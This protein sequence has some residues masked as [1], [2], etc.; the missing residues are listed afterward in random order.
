MGMADRPI[1]NTAYL[2]ISIAL[3]NTTFDVTLIRVMCMIKAEIMLLLM[4]IQVINF[5]H[6]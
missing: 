4:G 5:T 3:Q 6:I 2:W 1:F